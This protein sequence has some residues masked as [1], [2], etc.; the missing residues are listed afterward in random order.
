MKNTEISF[1][2]SSQYI[3]FLYR[4]N[5]C[6][7]YFIFQYCSPI[8]TRIFVSGYFDLKYFY[9][10][11]NVTVTLVVFPIKN[12]RPKAYKSLGML[13]YHQKWDSI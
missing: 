7:F 8:Y 1:W 11:Q 2:L 6:I 13:Y 10:V 12:N 9:F 5:I 3:L 4:H